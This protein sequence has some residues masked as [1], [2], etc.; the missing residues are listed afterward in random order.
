MGARVVGP[1]PKLSVDGIDK[2]K[3]ADA[4]FQDIITDPKKVPRLPQE[5]QPLPKLWQMTLKEAKEAWLK[6][7][8]TAQVFTK[9][10]ETA[11]KWQSKLVG[12]PPRHLLEEMDAFYLYVPVSTT[13]PNVQV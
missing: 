9:Q 6:N 5:C 10:W 1:A 11:F 4:M 2:Y 3:V 13:K 12:K 8:D 7:Q